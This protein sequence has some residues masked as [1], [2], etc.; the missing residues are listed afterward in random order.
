MELHELLAFVDECDVGDTE[1]HQCS[2]S[3]DTPYTH[4][5][6]L[7]SDIESNSEIA[8]KKFQRPETKEI[9]ALQSQAAALTLELEE[10]RQSRSHG[11]ALVL[12]APSHW[13]T[14]AD[15]QSRLRAAALKENEQLKAKV[16]GH[17]QNAKRVAKILKRTAADKV[18]HWSV[19]V[20]ICG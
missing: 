4:H 7:Y 17:R 13:K 3:T 18:L 5:P 20:N 8:P 10:I 19:V 12:T 15:R 2:A 1:S 11:S 9:A 14:E 16:Q 6:P